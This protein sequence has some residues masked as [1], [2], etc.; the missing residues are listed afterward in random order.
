MMD[1][2]EWLK[3]KINW[4]VMLITG[5]VVLIAVFNYQ[6]GTFLSGWDNLHPEFNFSLN[7]TRS[8]FRFGK[9][10]KD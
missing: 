6:P 3:E 7:L 9:N 8:F 4:P 10:I 1:I 2:F 5:A